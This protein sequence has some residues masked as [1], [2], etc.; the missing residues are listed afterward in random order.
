MIP[1]QSQ[2]TKLAFETRVPTRYELDNCEHVDMTSKEPWDPRS[3][4]LQSLTQ[5]IPDRIK[6]EDS[7]YAY[8]NPSDEESII[9]SMDDTSAEL[10]E[11]L[12]AK[13]TISSTMNEAKAGTDV[14]DR[15][16]LVSEERH[17]KFNEDTLAN[18]FGISGKKARAT[19]EVTH[20][21]GTRSALLPLSRRY[22]A[23]RRYKLRRLE[24]KFATDTFYAKKSLCCPI[25][26]PSY[27]QQSRDLTLHITCLAVVSLR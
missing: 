13:V 26:A 24:D 22:K 4:V 2:G 11:K 1:L 14:A 17:S 5:E 16:T 12:I 27:I 23:D 8:V 21:K 20:Q 7:S 15:R 9:H 25:H 6:L 18:R 3:V 19:L 10:K